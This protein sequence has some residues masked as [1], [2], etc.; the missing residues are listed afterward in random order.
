MEPPEEILRD[1]ERAFMRMDL[2]EI[3]KAAL[4]ID[5]ATITLLIDAG[6]ITPA[7][8]A[9]RIEE[10]RAVLLAGQESSLA[11]Q[12]VRATIE[13][14]RNAPDPTSPEPPRAFPPLTLLDGGRKD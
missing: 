14:I 3:R 8:A 13:T 1:A 5:I 10:I 4:V 12:A 6:L 9:Q 7:G 11:S 2:D